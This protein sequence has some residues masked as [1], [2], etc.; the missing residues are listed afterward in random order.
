MSRKYRSL[1]FTLCCAALWTL[2][3]CHLPWA[4]QEQ[5][6]ID[7]CQAHL[8]QIGDALRLYAETHADAFPYF[9]GDAAVDEMQALLD[10]GYLSDPV[11]FVCPAGREMPTTRRLEGRYQLDARHCS[12]RGLDNQYGADDPANTAVLWDGD[13]VHM[14]R[15]NVLFADGHV[16]L[17]D[18]ADLAAL[19]DQQTRTASTA[20]EETPLGVA[21]EPRPGDG[22]EDYAAETPINAVHRLAAAMVAGDEQAYRA[23]VTTDVAQAWQE[24]HG[25]FEAARQAFLAAWD[26]GAVEY[27][28]RVEYETAK[29]VQALVLVRLAGKPE[30]LKV[31]RD[32]TGHWRW[33]DTWER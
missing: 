24:L 7:A 28:E 9:P 6:R 11:I 2:A 23:S 4:A 25:D 21:V 30:W 18:E 19:R 10:L 16:E 13:P 20:P 33:A 12:Y 22:Q 27:T 17:L 8:R 1:A 29:H 32:E 3:A 15:V 26:P 14:G 5:P 31:A